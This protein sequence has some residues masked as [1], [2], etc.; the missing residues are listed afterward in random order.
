M[1]KP[2][3][4]TLLALRHTT[5]HPIQ[6]LLLIL[7]VALGVAMIVA[8]DLANGSAS[9]AFALSTDSIAG[10]ATH[11]IV[12]APGD[13][14]TSL[15]EQLRV[16]GGLTDIAPVVTGLVLLKN[17][18]DL[19]LQLLGIDPFA[20]PPFRT[21]LGNDSGEVSFNAL[22]S[23]LIEPNT[24]LLPQALAQQYNLSPG[25]PLTL[26]AGGQ[27]QTVQLVGLLQPGDELSQRA[28]NGLILTDISTAQE[29]LNMVGRLSH[30]DLILPPETDPQPILDR[31]PV[32]A[33]LQQ[34]ALRNQTLN[35][36]TAAFELNLSALSLLALIVGMFLIY[37]TIS[38]SV[39][40]RRP[41]L[42]TLRCL[43]VTRREI[44]GLVLGEALVLSA[45]GAI[46]GLGFGVILGRGLVGLVTQTI[47]DLYFTLTVQSVSLSPLT[48]YKGLVAGLAAGLLAAFVPALEA[49]TVPPNSALKRSLGEARMQRLIPGLAAASVVM[50]LAGWGLLNL[51]S[52]SLPLS[53]TALFII[54]LGSAF[55]SPLLTKLLMALLQRVTPRLFGIIG[56]MAP[57]DIVRSLS[58]TSV[59]IAAL[60]LAVTVII[61]VS[62]MIDSFRN[63]VV[64][65]LDSILAADIYISPAGQN[66]RVEGEINPDFIEQ[67]RHIEGVEAVSLLR[68]VVVFSENYEEVE[69]HGLSPEP[70]ED[71]RPMLWA[72]GSAAEL[73]AARQAG[74]VLVSEVFARSQG[75]P[76]DRPSVITLITERGPQPFDVVGIFYDYAVPDKGYVLMRL[77]TYRTHWPSD[78]AISNIALFLSPAAAPQADMLAQKITD[79]FA[80]KYFLS[81]SSNRGIKENALEVFDRTF[82]ITAALRLLATVVAFIGVLSAIMSLQLER[83]RELGTLRANGMS[84]LQLWGQTLL[85]TALM[86]LTAGLMAMPIGWA[87]AY[88]LVHFINLRSFGWSLQMRTSPDIFGLALVVA[89]LAALL[90]G[91]Y[92]VIRLKNMQIAVAVREE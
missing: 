70:R 89:L 26:L 44:F 74:G 25:D 23:L 35:Q 90:A 41:V 49:T 15:Y 17:A 46:I 59:T 29:V 16:E 69:L 12:A 5:R 28:L 71:R 30:I 19:P 66:L 83:T 21:Y 63:T 32:N 68:N 48:L 6:S 64:T 79:E 88:I 2:S 86:G 55:L 82:T 67:A 47:N 60:M 43:G 18:D 87:L 20:E 3:P 62:V 65:W 39:V 51:A 61:G 57:R 81:V 75:L 84:V 73:E 9:Q 11:Q 1:T 92:P 54:L 78:T 76:L 33:R 40:Q 56:L 14:P 72:M 91:I 4:F 85:E 31:L 52:R 37:N 24:V 45:L 53:F 13:L 8:I 42:G 27:T 10:K 22:L 58:R 36:M 50:M 38:F 7:G 34:A 80:A 77:Q